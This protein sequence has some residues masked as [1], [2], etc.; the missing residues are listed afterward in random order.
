MPG[1]PCSQQPARPITDVAI[2]NVAGTPTASMRHPL[3]GTLQR[4][5]D[6][7]RV[8]KGCSQPSAPKDWQPPGAISE[9]DPMTSSAV[10]ARA[11]DG[12]QPDRPAPTTATTSRDGPAIQPGPHNGARCGHPVR[13]RRDAGGIG[14]VDRSGTALARVLPAFHPLVTED[15]TATTGIGR[16]APCVSQVTPM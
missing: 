7:Q 6:L 9:V 1:T 5:H 15:P 14:Y 4:A 16:M 10:Q 12:R 3:R 11:D 2:L 13:L 8:L